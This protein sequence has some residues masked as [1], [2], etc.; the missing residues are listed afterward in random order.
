MI[1]ADFFR[2]GFQELRMVAT[3]VAKDALKWRFLIGW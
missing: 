3:G 1:R 2:Q